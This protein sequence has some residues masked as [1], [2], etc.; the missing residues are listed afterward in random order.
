MRRIS[1]LFRDRCF[2]D[3]FEK[4]V[5]QNRNESLH[6]RA[7]YLLQ[8]RPDLARYVLLMLP[9]GSDSVFQGVQAKLTVYSERQRDLKGAQGIHGQ[10]NNQS[11]AR[12][13]LS[14]RAAARCITG[15][16]P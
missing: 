8:L 3:R 5:P 16:V 4:L 11:A 10:Y 14:V 9:V 1:H 7:L 6:A 15:Q 2:G 12:Q 13:D